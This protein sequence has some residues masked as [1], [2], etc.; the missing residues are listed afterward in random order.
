MA[1]LKTYK[2]T[3]SSP[4][5]ETLHDYITDPDSPAFAYGNDYRR[6]LAVLGEDGLTNE[7][8][9]MAGLKTASE[10]NQ[11]IRSGII[12]DNNEILNPALIRIKV[13]TIFYIEFEKVNTVSFLTEGIEVVSTNDVAFKAAKLAELEADKGYVQVTKPVQGEMQIGITKESYPHVTVWIWARSLSSK[14]DESNELQG[15]LL[16]ITPFLQKV[17][18]NIDTNSGGNF[19]ITLPPLVAEIDQDNKWRIRKGDLIQ[20]ENNEYIAE[21]ELLTVSENDELKRNQFF[22]QNCIKSND[23]VFIRFETLTLEKEQR[24]KDA[25]EFTIDKKHIPN[26]IYD[27]I[28]LVD[29]T[30]STT[31]PSTNDVNINIS[32]RDLSKL[33]LNDGCYFF[34]LENSNG[35]VRVAGSTGTS[36]RDSLLVNRIFAEFKFIGLFNFTS[37]EKILKFII[38]QLSSIEVIPDSLFEA[39]GERRNKRFNEQKQVRKLAGVGNYTPEFKEEFARGIFFIVKL[40]IDESVSQ[41]KLAD[42]SFS[43]AQGALMNFIHSACQLP[44]VQYYADC[45]GDQYHLIVRKPPYDQK[46]L[47]SLI[48]GNVNTETGIPETAPAIVDIEA[49]D[50]LNEALVMNDAE[51]FSWYHFFPKGAMINSSVDYSTS[52]LPA[53]YFDEYAKVFGTTVFQQSHPYI[54]YVPMSFENNEFGNVLYKQAFSDIKYVVESHQYLPFTRKGTLILNGDRRIKIGNVIRY[55]PTGEIFFVDHVQQNFSINENSIERTTLIQVSRGMIEQFIYGLHLASE[56]GSKVF[57]SYFNLIDTRLNL[58]QQRKSVAY[59]EIEKVGEEVIEINE[60]IPWITENESVFEKPKYPDLIQGRNYLE[61]YNKYSEYKN[62]IIRFINAINESGYIVIIA[63]ADSVARTYE[64]QVRLWNANKHNAVPKTSKHE[65]GK[66]IDI[67]VRNI[68]SGKQV[69]KKSSLAEWEATG[70]PQLAR[71]MGFQ[72]GDSRHIGQFGNYI[73]RVHFQVK[74]GIGSLSKTIKRDITKAVTKYKEIG[75]LDVDGAF[76]NFKVNKYTFN[77]F[78]KNLQFK[79]E[80]NRTEISRQI[81]NSD[82]QGTNDASAIRG[83]QLQ[84]IKIASK[85]K[86]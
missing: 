57:V 79:P 50:V 21:G 86:K 67:N 63:G 55:K 64:Q 78:L 40:N 31:N 26:R 65:F 82:Q 48:E 83:S 61:S 51:A 8:R 15:E 1:E 27:M 11:L 3:H 70:V 16:D 7:H 39:Y 37:I 32:G 36:V 80:Y 81:Y 14:N 72:W 38:Q 85:R 75:E 9:M 47:I 41:R 34:P 30:A 35:I 18:T 17:I 33:F 54:P 5:L 62:K 49:E 84:E 60:E 28:G 69:Y 71:T 20:F 24:S 53:L 76:K 2:V 12:N 29:S 66:A 43:T 46:A 73:D 56:D 13:G 23:L 59:T 45:Y 4:E 77:F 44:L 19:Q 42:T 74:G 22:F 52:I 6:F 58:E 68:K 25:D 10:R